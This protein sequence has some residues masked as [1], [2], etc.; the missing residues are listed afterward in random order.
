M[1]LVNNQNVSNVITHVKLVKEHQ[2]IVQNVQLTHTELG[3]P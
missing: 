1:E 3:I 2:V